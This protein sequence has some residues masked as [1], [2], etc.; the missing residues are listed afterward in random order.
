MGTKVVRISDLSGKEAQD[1]ELARLVI[2]EH[3]QYAGPITLEVLPDE[4]GGLPDSESY[5]SIEVIQPGDRSGEKAIISL[6]NFNKLAADM[7]TVLRDAVAAQAQPTA[8]EAKSRGRRTGGRPGKIDY[9][10]L[11]HAGEPHRGRITEA[12]KQLVRDN[13]DK[14]N[15]RLREAGI[16]EIDPGD[17]T[18]KDRYGL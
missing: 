13:L 15:N 14:I 16:R 18:M 1:D 7:N 6:D 9:S 8:N 5:V 2:H 17:Q 10:S 4:I 12:E 3:P 11:E